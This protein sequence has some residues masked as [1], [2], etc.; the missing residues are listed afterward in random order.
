[1]TRDAG[2][3]TLD[4][5]R[6]MQPHAAASDHASASAASAEVSVSHS[7]SSRC[8]YTHTSSSMPL[9]AGRLL[10]ASAAAMSLAQILV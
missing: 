8:M 9:L 2:Y 4:D 1:L 6:E 10:M 5:S 7:R 3:A